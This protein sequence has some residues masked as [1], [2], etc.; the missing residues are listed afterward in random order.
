MSKDTKPNSSGI[1]AVKGTNTPMASASVEEQVKLKD[2][3]QEKYTVP[4][5]KS[6]KTVSFETPSGQHVY[7]VVM[8]VYSTQ[9]VWGGPF[10]V[11]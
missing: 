10:F 4:M 11:F 3:W 8:A 7:N 1:A 9:G 5:L 2:L 6:M